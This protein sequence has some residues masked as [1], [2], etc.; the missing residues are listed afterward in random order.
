MLEDI[1]LSAFE[2]FTVLRNGH[3]TAGWI[4]KDHFAIEYNDWTF[5]AYWPDDG[6][7]DF[8][9]VSMRCPGGLWF[10]IESASYADFENSVFYAYFWNSLSGL[11]DLPKLRRDFAGPRRDAFE[12]LKEKFAVS[13]LKRKFELPKMKESSN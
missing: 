8:Q 11:K 4:A 9:L 2:D 10:R 7:K 12:E 6:R 1:V 5:V 13:M 3:G